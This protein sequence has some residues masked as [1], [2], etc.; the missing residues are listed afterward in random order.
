MSVT[1]QRPSKTI[2]DFDLSWN[3][4]NMFVIITHITYYIIDIIKFFKSQQKRQKKLQRS[5][6]NYKYKATIF[7]SRRSGTVW[8]SDRSKEPIQAFS[9]IFFREKALESDKRLILSCYVTKNN[10]IKN[11]LAAK[12]VT[13]GCQDL[14][15]NIE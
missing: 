11:V 1:R 8:S 9:Q 4:I 3:T 7:N 6:Q 13:F 14:A 10:E 2:D 15:I 12:N 5:T